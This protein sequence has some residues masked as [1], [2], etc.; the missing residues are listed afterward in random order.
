MVIKKLVKTEE[1]ILKNSKYERLLG[2]RGEDRGIKHI[3]YSIDI[4][5][6]ILPEMYKLFGTEIDVAM[7]LKDDLH[8]EYLYDYRDLTISHWYWTEDW[9][10]DPIEKK[11]DLLDKE[12]E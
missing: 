12:T 2:F 1:E 6:H 8:R 7:L 5:P 4:G 10:D 3:N 11:L 9:L